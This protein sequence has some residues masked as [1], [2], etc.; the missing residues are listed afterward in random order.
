MLTEA[1]NLARLSDR[2]RFFPPEVT[3]RR[4]WRL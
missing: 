4:D 1:V 2:E 3:V